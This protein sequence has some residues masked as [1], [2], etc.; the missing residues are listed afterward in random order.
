MKR[1]VVLFWVG[2]MVALAQPPTPES[3]LGHK[4]GDDFYLAS[5]DDA[6]GYFQ[7]LAKATDKL[8]L[9]RVGKTT[10]GRDWYI[11]IISSGKNL[12]DLD[13]YKDTARRLALVKG[14]NDTQA[15]ALAHSGKVIVHID[16]GLHATEVACA[17]H[18][19]QLAYNLVTAKDPETTAILDN[20]I[21]LL[22]FSI[23]PDGQNMVVDW[24][25]QNL[26]TP[27]EVSNM[28]GLWQEYIGHDN[29]RDGYMNNMIE[30]QVITKTELEYYPDVFYNH[31]QTAP[32]PARIWI[33][34]FGDPV[35]LNPNPLMYRWVNVFGTAMAAYL[36][37]H[38]M[39]GAMHRGR[40]DDWYPGFVDHVNNFR[41]T[42]SFLTETALYRYATPHFY[43]IEDFPRDKQDLRAEVYYPSPWKGGWWRLGDAVRYMIGSSM[44]VLDTAAKNREELLYDRYRAGRDVIARFTKDPP[45]AYIIPREQRDTQTAAILV[46]KLMIDGIEVHQASR[47]FS[48][49]GA[50]YKEGDWV[51]LMDQPFASLVKELFEVQKYP[52]MPRI[53]QI[54]DGGGAGGGGRGG[55]GGGGAEAGA[56]AAATPAATP[57]AG[58]GGGR[59]GGGGG[60][61][62]GGGGRGGADGAATG[63]PAA[64]AATPA[65]GSAPGAPGAQAPPA[66]LPYDV[67]G[68]TL[69]MQ[70][71]VEVIPVAQPVTIEAR[72]VV[73]KLD[74]LEPIKG[75]VDGAGPVFS[76][77]HDTNAS[78]RAVND[79]LAGGGTVSFAKDGSAIY[80]T[81]KVEP[82]LEKDG[83]N[84]T[85]LK[86]A[87][88]A[89]G[90]KAPRVAI[91]EPWNG[92]I[93]EGW[94]RWIL[95][96]FHFPFKGV[97]N[98]EIQDGRLR[99]HYDTII[100][101]EMG[102]RQIMD[103]MQAGTVPGQYAGGIGETGAQN[104]RDFVTRGGTLITLG[105]AT[106]FAIDQF[107]LPVA[108]VVAGL[109]QDQFF[110]SGSLLKT[111][112]RDA[113]NPVVAGL[114]ATVPVMF[115]RNP[116][117]D[118]RPA[119]R[120]K[121][122]ASYVRDRNPLM[123]GFLLGAELIQ[124]KAAA[125]DANYGD[126]HIIMLAFRPQWRGQ[127][128]G[129][130][131]FLFNAIYYNPSMAEAAE[132]GARGGRG[133]RGGGGGGQQGAW[134]R[135]AEAVKTELSKLADLNRAYFTA[136]GPRAA[137]DGKQLENALDQF[138]RDR[139]PALDDLRAQVDDAA[140][141][142]NDATYIAQLRKFA[143]DLRT[144]DFSASRLD[145]LLDQYKLA[146]VP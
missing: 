83:V 86:D 78:L 52:E 41:N 144:K 137:E 48:A 131:K 32:F 119:F 87:A 104:L 141:S 116:V 53:A 108:N 69:P 46:E 84:A 106:M 102:T 18:T 42:V 72:A 121:V 95:E 101:A 96:Q 33:P 89:W 138:Q 93:D 99:D 135:E 11:A 34:P 109:R 8:K 27:F 76:F 50:T 123:S 26:G 140:T 85:S 19:I 79:I 37:E 98:A 120:G 130:Y 55:R 5:Y 88:A 67:T 20:V 21:L 75:K 43:T 44:A 23:N 47:D 133:G 107:N 112:I 113:N 122:L 92:N 36:D 94:T 77:S 29:N 70:M 3:V 146:V 127:S 31:H 132:G 12:A 13:K 129:T 2:C 35:S 15:R 68:W 38:D 61:G 4:P 126:G 73:R 139:L 110:C 16:G 128:H 145:D 6:L 100:I 90:V 9:V 60:R 66:Q 136:R 97:R 57:A 105:N 1:L 40:F 63:G 62:G 65:T 54:G 114:P 117:L 58:G 51:V 115:E 118:P 74:H 111:E 143:L 81:G 39:P 124:G 25:R 24:Y 134:R 142:R 71:G 17:Q 22:W 91:Y 64:A 59:G 7:K 45:Y 30:S 103:G 125:L 80:A 28:P 10:Q 49:N 82:I 14:L 56:A